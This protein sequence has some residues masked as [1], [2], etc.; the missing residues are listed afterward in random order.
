MASGAG[1][2][3]RRETYQRDDAGDSLIQAFTRNNVGRGSGRG[4]PAAGHYKLTVIQGIRI[5]LRLD[6]RAAIMF[7]GAQRPADVGAWRSLVA[8]LLWE[9]RVGGSNPSAPTNLIAGYA[10]FEVPDQQDRAPVAQPD[11]ASAF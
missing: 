2:L 9:Q 4:L 10:R 1:L 11:R 7:R 5:I 6:R 8:H 3:N